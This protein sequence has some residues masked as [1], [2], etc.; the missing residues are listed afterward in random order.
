MV[1]IP[2]IAAGGIIDGKGAQAAFAMGA[3]GVYMGTSFIAT[4]ENPA[5][6]ATKHAITNV[7]SEEF[8]EFKSGIGYLRTIPTEA[9]KKPSNLS[10]KGN[11]MGPT[12]IMEMVLKLVC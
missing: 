10:I 6:D 1:K 8:I 3:E 5:S 7:N 11:Q 4:K 9:G 2:V 12:H